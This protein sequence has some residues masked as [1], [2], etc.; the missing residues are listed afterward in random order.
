MLST[1]D[2][3]MAVS[4]DYAAEH[5]KPDQLTKNGEVDAVKNLVL[6]FGGLD[7]SNAN[8]EISKKLDDPISKQTGL[9]FAGILGHQFLR[10]LTR[11]S[12]DFANMTVTFEINQ[13]KK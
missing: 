10:N 11:M 8:V 5:F 3:G 12:I 7:I 6:N 4:S 13:N 2:T 9:Q 1:A